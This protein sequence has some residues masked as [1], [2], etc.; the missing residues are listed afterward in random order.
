MNRWPNETF[1]SF[2][3]DV[4]KLMLV[5]RQLLAQPATEREWQSGGL[6]LLKN[7]NAASECGPRHAICS[8]TIWLME[9]GANRTAQ[10][11]RIAGDHVA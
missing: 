8:W 1:G 9:F 3:L 6:S 11:K 5:A 10:A 2:R 7:A 4:G